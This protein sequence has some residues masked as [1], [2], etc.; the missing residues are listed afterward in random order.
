MPNYNRLH[1]CGKQA[2][3]ESME[4]ECGHG[5]ESESDDLEILN[6]SP[7]LTR[8]G[9][10]SR[11]RAMKRSQASS[12]LQGSSHKKLKVSPPREQAL[13]QDD[14]DAG[15]W[16]KVEKRKTK[17]AKKTVSNFDVCACRIVIRRCAK[18]MAEKSTSIYVCSRRDC[19]TQG[20]CPDRCACLI[21]SLLN[22]AYQLYRTYAIWFSI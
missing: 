20:G 3:A 11:A 10:H 1:C 5:G 21:H 14:E 18:H 6:M 15:E 16:T 17:K 9:S 7:A 8:S 4:K 12:P 19:Q 13:V 2:T 22:N